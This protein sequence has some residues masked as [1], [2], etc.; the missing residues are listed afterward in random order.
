MLTMKAGEFTR[1][2]RFLRAWDR[3][4]GAPD[5]DY[6]VHGTEI[7]FTL[8]GEHGG[9]EFGV[10]TNW[11]LPHVRQETLARLTLSGGDERTVRALL[12]PMG[13]ALRAHAKQPLY[14]GQ[15]P[16]TLHCTITGGECYADASFL[17]GD[18][19]LERLIAEGD[20]AVWKELESFY[21]EHV[22]PEGSEHAEQQA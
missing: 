10:L 14:E 22:Q 17:A 11:M 20:D 5:K 13:G 9:V 6:G 3:R 1:E 21:R 4:S 7:N 2:V 16:S 8:K 12:E 15:T 19:I 18:K